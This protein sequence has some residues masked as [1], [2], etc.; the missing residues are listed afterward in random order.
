VRST[1]P[2]NAVQSYITERNNEQRE[3]INGK[4]KLRKKE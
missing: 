4:K 1:P 3:K 2:V